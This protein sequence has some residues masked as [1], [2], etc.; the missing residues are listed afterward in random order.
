MKK[1]MIIIVIGVLTV[2]SLILALPFTPLRNSFN[3]VATNYVGITFAKIGIDFNGSLKNART[4]T[5][6][7]QYNGFGINFN[8]KLSKKR[9]FRISGDYS[10]MNEDNQGSFYGLADFDRSKNK[11]G[12]IGDGLQFSALSGRSETSVSNISAKPLSFKSTSGNLSTGD[13]TTTKQ[14]AGGQTYTQDSGGTHP[15]LD[16]IGNLPIGDGIGILLILSLVFGFIKDR[17]LIV[18]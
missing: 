4:L 11:A 17:K 16:P 2:I 15:G 3:S 5:Q 10:A 9:N 1:G 13:Q 6:S 12:G 8:D 18:F 14:S 7:S